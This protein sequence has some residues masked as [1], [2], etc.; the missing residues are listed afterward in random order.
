MKTGQP[1]IEACTYRLD[2]PI[3]ALRITNR[4]LQ[5]CTNKIVA[6]FIRNACSAFAP[7]PDTSPSKITWGGAGFGGD[8]CIYIG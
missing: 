6:A 5:S 4:A 8:K 7:F 3:F 1:V 2:K